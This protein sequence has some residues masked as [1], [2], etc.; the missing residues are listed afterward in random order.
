MD[1]EPYLIF[2][3]NIEDSVSFLQMVFQKPKKIGTNEGFRCYVLFLSF[4]KGRRLF[5]NNWFKELIEKNLDLALQ[6]KSTKE[7]ANK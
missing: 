6:I 1:C 7:I 2:E 3:L 4:F 5:K